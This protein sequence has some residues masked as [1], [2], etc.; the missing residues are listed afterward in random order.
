MTFSLKF[1]FVRYGSGGKEAVFVKA[2]PILA[3]LRDPPACM[4]SVPYGESGMLAIRIHG[5]F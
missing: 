5:Q 2:G 1:V 3:F 4:R